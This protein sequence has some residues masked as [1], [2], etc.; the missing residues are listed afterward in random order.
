MDHIKAKNTETILVITTGLLVL[1][2]IF[3]A[4]KLILAATIISV[5]GLAFPIVSKGISWVWYK[6][7]LALGYINSRILLTLIFI[8]FLVPVAFLARIFTSDLLRL[9]KRPNPNDSYYADRNH[10]YSAKDLKNV[11]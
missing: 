11:W 4:P 6:L 3:E 9:K 2:Y 8:I 1:Y 7:A 10:E 5:L